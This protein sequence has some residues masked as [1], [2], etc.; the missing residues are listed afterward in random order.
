MNVRE[1]KI[2]LERYDDDTLVVLSRDEEGNGFSPLED[3]EQ[4]LYVPQPTDGYN[5]HGEVYSP[6]ERNIA[7]KDAQTNKTKVSKAMIL[8]PKI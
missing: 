2:I 6:D 8:F 1:L 5:E 4:G 3:C 7:E